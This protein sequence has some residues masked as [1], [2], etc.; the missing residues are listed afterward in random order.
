MIQQHLLLEN[1]GSNDGVAVDE[2]HH[3]RLMKRLCS[4]FVVPRS[5][6]CGG[7][8]FKVAVQENS[9]GIARFKSFKRYKTT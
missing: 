5:G 6:S 9:A 8:L 4:S 1:D 3:Q 2:P 7:R